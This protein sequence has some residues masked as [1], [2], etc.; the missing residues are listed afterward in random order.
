VDGEREY[1]ARQARLLRA[2]A[3]RLDE[4]GDAIPTDI[5]VRIEEELDLVLDDEAIRRAW[6]EQGDKERE[7][8]VFAR[9]RIAG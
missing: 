5:F 8:W 7:P 2:L 3:A 4:G 1:R 9:S 6:A